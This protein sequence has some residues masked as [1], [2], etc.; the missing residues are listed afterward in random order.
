MG[1]ALPLRAVH[2]TEGTPSGRCL[3][4]TIVGTPPAHLDA[5]AVVAARAVG[6]AERVRIAVAARPRLARRSS[7]ALA[8]STVAILRAEG[9]VTDAY[10]AGRTALLARG[11]AGARSI[12]AAASR[13]WTI[14][15]APAPLHARRARGVTHLAGLAV[16]ICRAASPGQ[17]G[18]GG[19]VAEERRVRTVRVLLATRARLAEAS[20]VALL[21]WGTGR[22]S[23]AEARARLRVTAVRVR[24]GA[25]VRGFATVRASPR[26]GAGGKQQQEREAAEAVHGSI[27]SERARA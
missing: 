20:R 1:A 12:A 14:P 11:F 27:I 8:E 5:S 24:G 4:E 15:R 9:R 7:T 16:Q 22:I 13:P 21:I 2:A 10:R 17:A 18:S 26:I 3:N 25:T 19:G 6:P 23:P